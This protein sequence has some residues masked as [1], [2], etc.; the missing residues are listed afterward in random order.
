MLWGGEICKY[1]VTLNYVGV[2]IVKGT[3]VMLIG[4][5]EASMIFSFLP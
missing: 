4:L 3:N 2:S 5:F 1:V